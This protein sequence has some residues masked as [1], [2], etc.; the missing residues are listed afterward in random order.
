MDC[1][2]NL[3]VKKI[4][5]KENFNSRSLFIFSPEK[6]S[7]SILLYI[8][9]HDISGDSKGGLG[10]PCPPQF[11]AWPPSLFLNFPFQGCQMRFVN[12][13]AILS[14]ATD[15]SCVVIRKQHRENKDNQYCYATINNLLYFGWFVTFRC[16][17]GVI[18]APRI[19]S[20]AANKLRWRNYPDKIYYKSHYDLRNSALVPFEVTASYFIFTIPASD[21]DFQNTGLC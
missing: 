2:K 18:I 16:A 20:T 21:T 11:F 10:G 5:P 17:C 6:V 3:P 12:I 7:L 8:K 9:W 14:T 4:C 13:P 15:L 1:I 19:A